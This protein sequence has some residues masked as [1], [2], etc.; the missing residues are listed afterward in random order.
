MVVVDGDDHDMVA[1]TA[2]DDL[3][4]E[5]DL[6]ADVAVSAGG[7]VVRNFLNASQEQL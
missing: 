1:V 5:V 4:T 7:S 3:G 6:A 2:M